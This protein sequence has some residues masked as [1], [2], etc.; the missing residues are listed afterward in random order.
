MGFHA[1]NNFQLGYANCIEYLESKTKRIIAADGTLY[2]MGK[3]AGNAPLE[4][5]AMYMNENLGTNYDICQILEAIDNTIMDIYQKQYWGYN[6]FFYISAATKCHPNYVSFLMNKKTL[7]V[8]QITDILQSID[9]DKKL[10]YDAKYA[11][12]LYLDYQ[13]IS[14]DDKKDLSDLKELL[15]NKSVLLIG[16]GNNIKKQKIKVKKFI[17][18][19][20]PIIISVNYAPKDIKIDYVFLTKAKRYTQL[21]MDLKASINNSAEIIAT[22]NVTK[23]AGNFKYVLNYGSL[24]DENTE[25]IDNSLIMLLK[26]MLTVDVK[27]VYLAGFDGYSK[28]SDNYFNTSREYSFAKEKANYLNLYVKN[29]INEMVDKLQVNFITSSHYKR[30]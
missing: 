15:K 27:K 11:E 22:S 30:V 7:S 5:L 12:K 25:I 8:K 23:T 16:P 9:S 19:N 14:C 17:E 2:G 21:L 29:F 20:N 18:E 3:S 24:I 13:N 26:A 10:M 1:H 6:L 4:L 28:R